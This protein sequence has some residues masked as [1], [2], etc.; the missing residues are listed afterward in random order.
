MNI[1]VQAL[2]YTFLIVYIIHVLLLYYKTLSS[3]IPY[4]LKGPLRQEPRT[5]LNL[6]CS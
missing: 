2:R 5:V 1:L 3:T 6:S 4:G